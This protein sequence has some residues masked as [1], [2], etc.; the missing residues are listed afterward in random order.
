MSR[1]IIRAGK[2][3]VNERGIRLQASGF[4]YPQ[5]YLCSVAAPYARCHI[6]Y[7]QR[8][9]TRKAEEPNRRTRHG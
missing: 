6:A 4:R 9:R 5:T 3:G 1:E 7:N 8:R 2:K